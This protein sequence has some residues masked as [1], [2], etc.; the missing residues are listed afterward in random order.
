MLNSQVHAVARPQPPAHSPLGHV[1]LGHDPLARADP[2]AR[3]PLARAF[4]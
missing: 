2:P 4:R 1:T 3:D